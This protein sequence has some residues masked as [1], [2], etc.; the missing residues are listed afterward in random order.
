MRSFENK[1]VVVTWWT[2]GI[3]A[4][5][6]HA[7]AQQW[8]QVYFTGR[9]SDKWHVVAE[10]S[11]ATFSQVDATDLSATK[12]FIETIWKKH[13]AIDVLYL[14]AWSAKWVDILETTE[15]IF[16]F[17]YDLNVKSPVM[18]IQYA[19]PYLKKWSS[20]TMTASV[21][22]QAWFRGFNIYGSTKAAIINVAKTYAWALAEH[23]IRVNTVSPWP[24]DTDIFAAVWIPEDQVTGT[25]DFLWSLT[26]MKRM[27]TA[28]EIAQTVVFLSSDKASYITWSDV[29]VDGWMIPVEL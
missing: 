12:T 6:V 17:T 11:W 8:A 25:K 24:I 4:A 21:A 29:V 13:G 28:D 15:E 5:S 9:N 19:L 22:G 16:D 27:G 10:S 14:N 1:V 20:I 7:F 18:T 3:W 26:P 2:S 23:W